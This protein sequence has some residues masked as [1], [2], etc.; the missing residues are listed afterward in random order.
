MRNIILFLDDLLLLMK[1]NLK[2]S[3]L[4]VCVWSIHCNRTQYIAIYS[5][6]FIWSYV[7]TTNLNFVSLSSVLL[8]QFALPA[9]QVILFC[10]CIGADPFN[11]PL[12]VVNEDN[13]VLSRQFLDNLDPYTVSQ[14]KFGTVDDGKLAVRNGSMWGVLH[15]PENFT[16]ALIKRMTL[17]EDV[18]D[19]IIEESTIKVYPDLTNQQISYTMERSFKDAFQIFAKKALET[20]GRNPQL[21]EFPLAVSWF[22]LMC[23]HCKY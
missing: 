4:S 22:D 10:I 12:A 5:F 23:D 2:N 18:D 1:I 11:I 19:A 15:I 8:F 7:W 21:A 3:R 14:Y 16:L 20:Y 13:Q 17:G 6:D 9:I